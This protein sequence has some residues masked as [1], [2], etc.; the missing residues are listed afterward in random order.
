[1]SR[2]ARA[3]MFERRH[4]LPGQMLKPRPE[5]ERLFIFRH[6]PTVS[7]LAHWLET[8]FFRIGFDA[9]PRRRNKLGISRDRKL[10]VIL[11]PRS[12]GQQL[13]PPRFRHGSLHSLF[14]GKG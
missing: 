4:P 10:A 6:L 3:K 5:F 7:V 11:K 13:S 2:A 14:L 12:A 1:M 9:Q 8:C